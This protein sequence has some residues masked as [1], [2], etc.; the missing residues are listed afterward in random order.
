MKMR[1]ASV[2]VR[3]T[4]WYTLILA[5]IVAALFAGVFL[6]V[7]ASL[8]GELGRQVESEFLAIARGLEEE[9][10][11]LAEVE[12]EMSGQIIQA[13]RGEAVLFETAAFKAFGLASFR[14][15]G[16]SPW[17]TVRTADGDRLRLRSG[18]TGSGLVLTVGISEK[19]VRH[20]LRTLLLILLLALPAGLVLAAIGGS[21]LAGRLLRPV[22]AMAGQAERISA[23]NLSSRLPIEDPRDE[24]GQMA[25]VINRMLSRLEASFDR[26]SRF[27]A[28]AS[29]E[30][31]TPLTVIRSVGE[32]A[33]QEGLDPAAYRDRI[34]SMLEEVGRLSQLVDN[35]LTLTRADAGV[36][37]LRR[38]EIDAFALAAQSIEDLRPLAEEKRQELTLV[39]DGAA[40]ITADESTLRLALV[41]LLDNAIKY[42]P[43]AGTIN[44]GVRVKDREVLIEV[45]DDGP[46]I[47]AEQAPKVFERFYRADLSRSSQ[48]GGAGLGLAIA[49]WAVEANGGRIELESREGDGSTFRLVI[50]QTQVK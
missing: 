13:R 24:F 7:R 31:R 14:P 43:P 26:L 29:H 49:R 16:T 40:R 45:A 30:L 21:V 37:E 46:G 6:V 1:P 9:P 19:S 35:L 34:G 44:V 20:A 50:P 12:T 5:A 48:T 2:R 42:T 39:S 3:L 11:E 23:E 28:D 33:L 38:K 25:G 32:V 15:S 17:Q 36:V 27:T 10:D 47:P 18:R 41:N 4:L 22:A 8:L